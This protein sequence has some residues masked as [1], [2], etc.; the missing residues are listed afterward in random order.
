M[1]SPYPEEL[2]LCGFIKYNIRAESIHV[3][4]LMLVWQKSDLIKAPFACSSDFG[5]YKP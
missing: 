4:N 2:R 1:Y 5:V 3:M